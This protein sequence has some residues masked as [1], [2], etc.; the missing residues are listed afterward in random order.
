MSPQRRAPNATARENTDVTRRNRER[1]PAMALAASGTATTPIPWTNTLTG[2]SSTRA[3]FISPTADSP[4][5]APIAKNTICW[6]PLMAAPSTRKGPQAALGVEPGL[7]Q[8][9]SRHN[10]ALETSAIAAR[11]AA[12]PQ[13]RIKVAELTLPERKTTPKAGTISTAQSRSLLKADRP[14]PAAKSIWRMQ[15]W[16]SSPGST[17]PRQM[18]E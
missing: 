7:D 17:A 13:A 14:L 3:S 9:D 6:E 10:P 2:P 16:T 8:A 18:D 5:K 4:T 15:S 12:A 11:V 1:P